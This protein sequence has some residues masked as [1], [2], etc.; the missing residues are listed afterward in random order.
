MDIYKVNLYGELVRGGKLSEALG[1]NQAGGQTVAFVGAGGKTTAIYHLAEE[2]AAMGKRVIITTTTHMFLP[3]KYGV[4]E[5]NEGRL[6][7]MLDLY[8]IAVTGTPCGDGKMTEVSD[9]FYLRAK[10][11]ADYILVEADGSKRL[12]I[13][14]PGRN[15]P[16]L[17][18]DTDLVVIVAGLTCLS[19][20]LIEVCHRWERAAEIL[21]CQL[22]HQI[23]PFDVAKLIK[24]GYCDT[25]NLP[26]RILLNQCDNKEQREDALEIVSCLEDKGDVLLSSMLGAEGR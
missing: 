20:P 22:T 3:P 4:L 23:E 16:V 13:K 9:S 21:G 12:P 14:V 15:E 7:K 10:N 18:F 1:V 19:R 25:I 6:L 24:T 2:L 26:Y 11:R 5:E 17:P 8:G